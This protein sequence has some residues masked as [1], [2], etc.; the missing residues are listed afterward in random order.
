LKDSTFFNFKL[1]GMKAIL[2]SVITAFLCLFTSSNLQAQCTVTNL[3]V[4]VKSFNKTTCEV[5]FDLTWEQEVNGGNKNAYLHL[6]K[7]AN[8]HMPASRW[9]NMYSNPPASPNAAD[10]AQ[11]LATISILNNGDP[12]PSI[13]LDYPP[14]N[15]VI[16]K[17]PANNPGLAVVKTFINGGME[18]MTIRNIR[19]PLGNCSG[20][21][22]LKG[23]VWASQASNGKNVHCVSQGLTFNLNNPEVSGFKVCNPRSYSYSIMNNGTVPITV[24]YNLYKDDGDGIFEPGTATGLDGLPI[25]TSNNIAIASG[26]FQSQSQVAYPG[27]D[28]PGETGSLWMEVLTITPAEPFVALALLEDPGCIPLP[29]NIKSFHANRKKADVELVWETI[30]EANNKGFEVQ[31]KL[32]TGDFATIAFVSTKAIGG[33]SESE[34]T[35]SYTDNY[36]TTGI[37][38][39]RLLQIDVDG[40]SKFSEIRN[41]RGEGQA[42]KVIVYPNPSMNGKVTVVFEAAK[43]S[44]DVQLMDMNGRIINQWYKQANNIQIDNLTPGYYNLRIINRDSGQQTFEKIIINKR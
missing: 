35:Y 27:N 43:Q 29:V 26:A 7:A 25:F 33:N 22:T 39:Y 16:V 34:L 8:Y 38:Q 36:L 9:S 24:R 41:V 31:R 6:W 42:V 10:L 4:N 21:I 44:H 13:G 32:G 3:G 15:S 17:T 5:V 28:A 2:F 19:M 18:R 12:V 40:R 23:D 14:D 1:K 30:Y 37:S 20:V 11:S